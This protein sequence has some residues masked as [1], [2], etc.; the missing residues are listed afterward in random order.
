MC[1]SVTAIEHYRQRSIITWVE[2]L[3][4]LVHVA[5][6]NNV[7]ILLHFNAD[8]SFKKSLAL[9]CAADR[10]TAKVARLLLKNGAK[11]NDDT[12]SV[13][14]RE[15]SRGKTPFEHAVFFANINTTREMVK[16]MK[17]LIF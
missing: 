14:S 3:E 1:L 9:Y 10:P 11:P 8:A 17:T 7:E 12:F 15:S 13:E 6:V 4:L 2:K 5:A 16:W